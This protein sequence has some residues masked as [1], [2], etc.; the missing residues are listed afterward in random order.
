VFD[1]DEA[2]ACRVVDKPAVALAEEGVGLAAAVAA[3]PSTR[4]R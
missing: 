2:G 1:R 4:L 3:S